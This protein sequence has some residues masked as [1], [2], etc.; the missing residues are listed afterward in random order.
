MWA[1][2]VGCV[3]SCIV[4]RAILCIV[5]CVVSSRI[6]RFLCLISLNWRLDLHNYILINVNVSLP[7]IDNHPTI[8][9]LHNFKTQ[10]YVLITCL[11]VHNHYLNHITW[12][13]I[14]QSLYII[15]VH[16]QVILQSLVVLGYLNRCNVVVHYYRFQIQQPWHH[17]LQYAVLIQESSH[18]CCL[19]SLIP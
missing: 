14:H 7:N 10:Q 19:H 11:I 5:C 4:N 3:C 2:I 18:V 8:V 1:S 6:H 15:L 16:Q 12:N 9:Q 13:K 17:I